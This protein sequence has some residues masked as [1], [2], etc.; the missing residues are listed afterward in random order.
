MSALIKTPLLALMLLLLSSCAIGSVSSR[1]N[2]ASAIASSSAFNKSRIST[3]P[4]LVTTFSRIANTTSPLNVYIEGDGFAWARRDRPSSNPTPKNPVG[5]KLASA[6]PSPNVLYIA[7][8]C[9][10]DDDQSCSVLYWTDGRF[11][12]EVIDSIDQTI[13]HFSTKGQSINII[14]FSGGGAL[15]VLIAAKR[16]DI[17]TIRTVAGNLDHVAMHNHHNVTQLNNSLNAADYAKEVQDIPQLHFVGANDKIVPPLVSNSF[18]EHTSS[19][20]CIH[21]T[22]IKNATHTKGWDER[23]QELLNIPVTCKES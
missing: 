20:K 6:D 16:N 11:A 5:L 17:S 3:A 12:P 8:P 2:N 10:Y 19:Q 13:N 21:V 14:G 22:N 1:I 15:A 23:W 18:V 7:R 9:Q 4:F